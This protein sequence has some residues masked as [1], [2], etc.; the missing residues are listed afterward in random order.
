MTS[1]VNEFIRYAKQKGY[2]V[3]HTGQVFNPKGK[4]IS[5]SI[6]KQKKSRQGKGSGVYLSHNFSVSNPNN[7]Y[8]SRPVPTHKFV[9]YL[10]YGEEAFSADCVRHYN[11]NSLDNSWDNI[12]IGT[13]MD[14]HL[15]AVRNGKA[16]ARKEKLTSKQIRLR[17]NIDLLD[18]L[19][20]RGFN[21]TE[22]AS[23]FGFEETTIRYHK[24]MQNIY[25]END[26]L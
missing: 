7:G 19:T 10:K 23:L 12:L 9:A 3:D 2:T 17:D 20:K 13:H 18:E 6:Q 14:N 24:K 16:E 8:E 25:K 5:G 4:P 15:D 11:D 1:K 21:N 22:I 26:L